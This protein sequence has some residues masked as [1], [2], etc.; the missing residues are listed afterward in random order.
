M[1]EN[2]T[3]VYLKEVFP[4]KEKVE[5]G[6]HRKVIVL[7]LGIQPFTGAMAETMNVKG[8]LFDSK[9]EPHQNIISVALGIKVDGPQ[10]VRIYRAPDHEMPITLELRNVKVEPSISV[11]ADKETPQYAAT[12]TLTTDG[13]PN[14]K[15]LMTLISLYT[16]Q[17]LVTIEPEQGDM[18][19]RAGEE[20]EPRMA[21]AGATAH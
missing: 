8:R 2:K 19:T 17:V 4:Q 11:R 6:D 3:A 21:A 20:G 1:F 13:M 15:D 18:L 12:L 10:T 5:D 16:E 9:G 7:K 14:P